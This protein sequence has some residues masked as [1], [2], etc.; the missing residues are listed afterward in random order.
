MDFY[1]CGAYISSIKCDKNSKIT[2][3]KTEDAPDWKI[4]EYYSYDDLLNIYSYIKN[5]GRNDISLLSID[6]AET[7]TQI[8]TTARDLTISDS[9]GR[10]FGIQDGEICSNI[11]NSKLI[12]SSYLAEEP[13]YTIILPTDTYTIVGSGDEEITTSFADDYMSAA[14]T[15]KSSTPITIS[16][17]LNEVTVGT[18]AND[19]YNITYTTYDTIFDEMTLSGRANGVVTS[20]RNGAEVTLMGADD[21]TATATVS[22]TETTVNAENLSDYS[23]VT[24]LCKETDNTTTIQILDENEKLTETENLSERK[25]AEAPSYDLRSGEYTEGKTLTFTKDDDTIIYYT[26]D[27]SIPTAETGI[28]Y[29]LPIEINKSMTVKAIS[30]RYGYLDSEVVELSYTLPEV[31]APE[32][33]VSEGAYDKVITV[34]LSTGD[35]EDTIYYTLDGSSPLENGIL[36]TVPID[37]SDDACLQAYTQRNGCI[38]E[39]SAYAYTVDPTYPFYFSNSLTNQD[40]NL[41]TA[42]NLATLSKVKLTLTKLHSGEHS[43]TFLIAF[44][45]SDDKLIYANFKTETISEDM[46]EV[47]I[48]I[49]DSVSTA[50][51]IKAFAWEN[52]SSMKPICDIWKENIVE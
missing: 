10:T 51:T 45:N 39:I 52:L 37:I 14:V 36:Y 12:S 4:F 29:S 32:S 2:F 38:S 23:S 49:D 43:G 34:E 42:E 5:N 17:D 46:D 7:Y 48:D 33:N 15:A 18:A 8:I 25:Q 27:G 31:D 20:T 9:Q 16:G 6:D 1:D 3:R 41:I 22:E 44:Y 26:T 47:E 40:G 13:T 30:T 50:C 35:Y 21:V 28:I 19:A 24:V 11:D